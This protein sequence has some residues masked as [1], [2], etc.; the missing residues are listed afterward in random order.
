[1]ATNKRKKSASRD[2]E[3]YNSTLRWLSPLP[4]PDRRWRAAL[5]LAA[6]PSSP[7]RWTDDPD[8]A[9]AVQYVRA[10]AD[11]DTDEQRAA[12]RE[13]WPSISEAH[14]LYEQ[15]GP[16][17]WAF[18]AWILTNESDEEI[19]SRC[20]L[21]SD[22]V[23]AYTK[24]FYSIDREYLEHPDWLQKR[25]FGLWPPTFG[26]DQLDRF[27]AWVALAGGATELDSLVKAF[28]AAWQTDTPATLIVYLR[29][30][31]GVSLTVQAFISTHVLPK[32]ASTAEA[33]FVTH[34][35]LIEAKAE[36]DPVR[37][38]EKLDLLKRKMV[39]FTFA[40]LSGA[41]AAQL[42]RL[43]HGPEKRRTPCEQSPNLPVPL[44]PVVML[45]SAGRMIEIPITV[46]S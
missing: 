16:Q 36:R 10:T 25:M 44:D 29:P 34:L 32:N 37:K 38:E 23:A 17:K 33:Y 7:E 39:A 20:G 21:S 14:S 9:E 11:C 18:E 45:K 2:E 42:K 26:N 28:H 31:A 13:Q 24:F 43:L 46:I 5:D 12:L 22:V 1:M 41:S 15:D 3:S 8:V 35:A 27:W 19:G 40:F 6:E 4:E 30:D